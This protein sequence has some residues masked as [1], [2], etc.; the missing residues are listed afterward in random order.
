MYTH[1]WPSVESL[2]NYVALLWAGVGK[3][4]IMQWYDSV[5]KPSRL[6]KRVTHSDDSLWRQVPNVR[7]TAVLETAHHLSPS[8][9][10]RILSIL[11]HTISQRRVLLSSSHLFRR[12][13]PFLLGFP[14]KI[15]HAFLFSPMCATCPV[16]FTL[17]DLITRDYLADATNHEARHDVL[18]PSPLLPYRS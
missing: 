8:L 12:L 5:T 4:C 15:L 3:P 1:V 9:D 6:W 2:T 7:N 11:S 10:G 18:F 17:L 13:G 16:P 14:T